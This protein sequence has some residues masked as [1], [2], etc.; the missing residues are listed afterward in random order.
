MTAAIPVTFTAAG[1]LEH[2][3][4]DVHTDP[5]PAP[6]GLIQIGALGPLPCWWAALPPH[7][8]VATARKLARQGVLGLLIA[9]TPAV[10]RRTLCVSVP[11]VR[12]T[13]VPSDSVDAVAIA[14]LR[15]LRPE[16][17][18]LGQ[19]LAVAAAIDVDCAGRR[20]FRAL[21]SG[22]DAAVLALPGNI[23]LESRRDWVLLQ[24]TRML[25]LRFVESEGWLD[26]RCD[27]L[28]RV[29]D[30]CLSSNRQVE[31]HLLAPLFF[32]TLNRPEDRRTRRARSFGSIPFLNGGLF[33]AHPIDRKRNWAL[34]TPAWRTLFELL[35]DS[36]EVTLDR[37][38]VGDRVNPELLGRV[39]EGVME[40]NIRKAAGAYYTPTSLVDAVLRDALASHLAPLSGRDEA[41]LRASLDC[42]D[43]E[44]RTALQS[45]TILD[46]A[47]GSGAF[48]MGALHLI[49]GPD[50][51]A[52]TVRNVITRQL[53]GVD[54]DPGAVR[55]AELRLWLEVLRAMR[56]L[57][58]RKVSPLPNLD[59]T[60]RAGNALLD[61]FSGSRLSRKIAIRLDRDRR[62]VVRS[63]GADRRRALRQLRDTER[64]AARMLLVDRMMILREKIADIADQ[65]RGRDLF[66]E[67]AR[68]SLEARHAVAALRK[69]LACV[70]REHK[71]LSAG[72]DV[73]AFG[74][75][76]AFAMNLARGGFDLV[77]GNPP[78]VRAERLPPRE[79]DALRG[80]YRWW[81]GS[82]SGGWKHSPDLS[83]A[84]VERATELLKAGGTLALLVPCKL[85]TA[86]YATACR[87]ALSHNH[88]LHAVVD[89]DRDPRAD[90]A[91]TTYPLAI[92]ASRKAAAPDHR[93]RLQ[94][95]PGREVR[96]SAWREA[97]V[98]RLGDVAL[99]S[100]AERLGG[101]GTLA[102]RYPP[103]L[104]VKTGANELF[105]DPPEDLA[106]Y[107]RLAVRGR[108]V[109]P[110]GAVPL[111]RLLWP[112]DDGG[113]P[114]KELPHRLQEYLNRHRERLEQRSDYVAGAWWRIYRTETATSR[115][116]VTWSDLASRLRAAPLPNRDHIPVNSCYVIAVDGEDRMLAIA[117]WLNSAPIRALARLSAEPAAN[118]YAR[119]R[120]GNVGSVPLPVSVLDSAELARIAGRGWSDTVAAELDEM[121]AQHLGLTRVEREAIDAFVAAGG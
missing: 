15:R 53:F 57:P 81:R 90:F 83:V 32:G 69:E 24:V 106:E 37:G 66:G 67:R 104:G 26:G 1:L 55:H 40:P 70:T 3:G 71:R 73:A 74:I 28:A 65:G 5:A 92:I 7:T 50:A 79:R 21:R 4:A 8:A 46:P 117:A 107:S 42:P 56:G 113:A 34:P 38:D 86:D 63:H 62:L 110:L 98:W 72:D 18:L 97:G 64:S 6:A 27:F 119:Y 80:R 33:E 82:N 111:H 48:L 20:A 11:P 115:W 61:P 13:V 85:A 102:E 29:F 93:I 52:T 108:D 84:F 101:T 2:I 77:V 43:P 10:S 120:A 16:P 39:F 100:L 99:Q 30:D 95:G 112:A 105:I 94:L 25:F 87:A 45:L 49:T 17:S 96:Q 76:T 89:L 51:D 35:V 91:A 109:R 114:L 41:Q 116:R 47:V 58:V 75:E 78:W 31:R 59:T 60:I 22:I 12:G 23:S 54:R 103:S 36:F 88:T 68:I 121:A 14:R 118:G 44:L 19:A 9:D